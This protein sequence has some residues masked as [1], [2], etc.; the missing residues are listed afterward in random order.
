MGLNSKYVASANASLTTFAGCSGP[1]DGGDIGDVSA[2]AGELSS[3]PP[4]ELLSMPVSPVLAP[5]TPDI[6]LRSDLVFPL[7]LLPTPLKVDKA[8]VV[9]ETFTFSIDTDVCEFTW[10]RD[11]LSMR[12]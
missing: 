5:P 8:R 1:G 4:G 9:L 7:M 6:M 11:T 3:I 10:Q 2:A 12:S